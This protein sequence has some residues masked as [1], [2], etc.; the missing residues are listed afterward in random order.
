DRLNHPTPKHIMK[1][2]RII[3][4][5]LSGMLL[6]AACATRADTP[7]IPA[8]VQLLNLA[9][10]TTPPLTGPAR[11]HGSV[12]RVTITDQSFGHAWR[13]AV[14]ERQDPPHHIQLA[15]PVVG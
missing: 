3:T 5:C 10:Q 7:V 8:G 13:V 15:V 1:P 4:A 11:A 9:S 6:L 2:P 14:S 12:S